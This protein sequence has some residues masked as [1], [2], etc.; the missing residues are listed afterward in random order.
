MTTTTETHTI[1]LPEEHLF[2]FGD[3]VMLAADVLKRRD[4]EAV[5]LEERLFGEGE[6]TTCAS[7][8]GQP[9]FFESADWKRLRTVTEM[10]PRRW[11]TTTVVPRFYELVDWRDQAVRA[12]QEAVRFGDVEAGTPSDADPWTTLDG[13][14]RLLLVA[15]NEAL[16]AS[17]IEVEVEGVELPEIGASV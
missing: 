3:A 8:A 4:R 11:F 7:V 17:G 2:R 15:M 5:R 12:V 16:A 9:P 14:F 10:T 6:E 1:T 13:E